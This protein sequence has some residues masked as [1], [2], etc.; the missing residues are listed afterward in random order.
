MLWLALEAGYMHL[1][2]ISGT[3][4]EHREEVEV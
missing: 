3:R 1:N 2:L 4:D